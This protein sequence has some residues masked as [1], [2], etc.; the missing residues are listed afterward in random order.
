MAAMTPLGLTRVGLGAI[1]RALRRL[2]G[3]DVMLY[4]GGV[5]FYAMLAGFPA[6]AIL[7][8]VYGLLATPEEASVQAARLATLLPDSARILFAAELQRLAVTP[9]SVL[10]TQSGVAV[11]VSLY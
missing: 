4:T 3:R 6:L 1:R 7:V 11:L 10:S 9:L 8:S 5:S 2:W